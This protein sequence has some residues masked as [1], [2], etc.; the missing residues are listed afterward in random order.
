MLKARVASDVPARP[1]D[2]VG[3]AF[4]SDRLSIFRRGDGRA[5]RTTLHAGANG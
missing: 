1:G 5:V 3:L 4:R 2:Q